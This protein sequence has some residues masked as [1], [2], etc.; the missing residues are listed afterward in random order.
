LLPVLLAL[1]H[2]VRYLAEGDTGITRSNGNAADEGESV[3]GLALDSMASSHL[4]RH[5]GERS[6]IHVV[7]VEKIECQSDERMMAEA[8]EE[9]NA[10]ARELSLE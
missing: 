5:Q 7:T 8:L 10:P 9:K 2:T 3:R 1:L 4:S 6:I